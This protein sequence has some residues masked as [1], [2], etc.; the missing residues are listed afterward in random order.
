VGLTGDGTIFNNVVTGSPVT[1]S[2][3]LAPSLL[4]QAAN[5]AFG[6][7]TSASATPTFANA[8]TVKSSL[9]LQS[10]Y[11]GLS[12]DPAR[13]LAI[14]QLSGSVSITISQ[15]GAPAPTITNIGG[16]TSFASNSFLGG[17]LYA[18]ASA[19]ANDFVEY[20]GA[21]GDDV[22]FGAGFTTWQAALLKQI[23]NCRLWVAVGDGGLAAYDLPSA[24]A[25]PA[26]GFR[27]S[28]SAGD[29]HFKAVA[30]DGATNTFV[31]TGIT[32]VIDTR[33]VF[34]VDGTNPASIVYYINGVQVATITTTLPSANTPLGLDDSISGLSGNAADAWF[35]RSVFEYNGN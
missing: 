5:T 31:D 13:H 6:N 7:F 30:S 8:S 16:P 34:F 12:G 21:G 27:Y 1:T 3:T 24:G 29:T 9:G 33:Y 35:G 10:S 32:P 17:Y 26:I 15:I 28:T 18:V 4:T 20:D 19:G 2:G 25:T 14:Y 22:L 23:T 11:Q